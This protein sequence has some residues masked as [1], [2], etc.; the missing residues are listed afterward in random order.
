MENHGL[1][2]LMH[3]W[4]A[5]GKDNVRV[6]ESYLAPST[7]KI[8]VGEDEQKVIK[9]SW[10]VALRIVNDALWAAIK[11]GKLGAYSIGGVANRTPLDA[12]EG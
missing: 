4:E 6:L 2:D 1:V 3:S 11:E 10:L 12:T 7:F 5:L 8:G 9:G